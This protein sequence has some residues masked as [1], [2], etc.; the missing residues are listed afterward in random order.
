MKV[1]CLVHLK[2]RNQKGAPILGI[3]LEAPNSSSIVKVFWMN[4][5]VSKYV[6][7]EDIELLGEKHHWNFQ[8]KN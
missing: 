1:G 5:Y 6:H 2:A 4:R 3:L 7:V 8:K